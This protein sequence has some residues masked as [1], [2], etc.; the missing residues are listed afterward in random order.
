MVNKLLVAAWPN[1][2]AIVTS[3]RRAGYVPFHN[4]SVALR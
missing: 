4:P 3:F 1:E 2:N